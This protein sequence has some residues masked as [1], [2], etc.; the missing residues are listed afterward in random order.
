[1]Q[2]KRGEPV[3]MRFLPPVMLLSLARIRERTSSCQLA[4]CLPSQGCDE[5]LNIHTGAGRN[6]APVCTSLQIIAC[7]IH[8]PARARVPLSLMALAAVSLMAVKPFSLACRA[9]RACR[10]RC[11][12]ITAALRC[13]GVCLAAIGWHREFGPP[14]QVRSGPLVSGDEAPAEPVTYRPPECEATNLSSASERTDLWWLTQGRCRL[15][16]RSNLPAGR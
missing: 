3:C 14:R 7:L 15:G 6:H 10:A 9:C 11:D 12:Q 2:G 1:M 4:Y 13:W 8:D 5:Y 16:W